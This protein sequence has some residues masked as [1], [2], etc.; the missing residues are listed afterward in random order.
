[1]TNKNRTLATVESYKIGTYFM[2][3]PILTVRGLCL[4]IHLFMQRRKL[5]LSH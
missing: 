4:K 5:T 3:A 1:M 2:C